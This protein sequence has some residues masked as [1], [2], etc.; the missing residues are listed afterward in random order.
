MTKDK[1]SF[2]EGLQIR[3]SVVGMDRVANALGKA[4]AI[5][6][7]LQELVTSFAWG[8][9]WSRPDL[10]FRSRS[11]ATIGMLIGL[12]KTDELRVHLVGGLNN[13]LTLVELREIIIHSAVYAGFPAALGAMQILRTVSETHSGEGGAVGS[14]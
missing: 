10:D 12:G 7:P 9:I 2:C 1:S 11:I 3:Q 4:D 8:E 14:T 13:G 6:M 5:S